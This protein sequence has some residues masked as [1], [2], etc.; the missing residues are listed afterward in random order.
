M[1]P[2]TE[3]HYKGGHRVTLP[4]S[5]MSRVSRDVMLCH[6]VI[7]TP[8]RD[9]HTYYTFDNKYYRQSG[10]GLLYRDPGKCQP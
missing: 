7:T 2:G 1:M 5:V 4:P 9:F 10:P 3:G 6:G 8:E